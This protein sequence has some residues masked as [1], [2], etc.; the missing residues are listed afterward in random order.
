MG[1]IGKVVAE[2]APSLTGDFTYTGLWRQR[3]TETFHAFWRDYG[4]SWGGWMQDDPSHIEGGGDPNVRRY[5]GNNP[6]NE[7][8][9]SGL[10]TPSKKREKY[11]SEIRTPKKGLLGLGVIDWDNPVLPADI[12]YYYDDFTF[13]LKDVGKGSELTIKYH[14]YWGQKVDLEPLQEALDSGYAKLG[15]GGWQVAMDT[16]QKFVGKN[17]QTYKKG[18]IDTTIDLGKPVDKLTNADLIAK[19]EFK[20]WTDEVKRLEAL[21]T[22]SEEERQALG[23]AR[24]RVKI[25]TRV[26]NALK[27][28]E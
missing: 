26:Y 9:L 27:D 3:E 24:I 23:A 20:Y 7:T 18:L 8:D 15:L 1:H 2:T 25:Y 11:L 28:K 4:A 12:K 17:L 16:A 6:A 10:I 13:E 21:K 19:L 22:P 14:F 5:A